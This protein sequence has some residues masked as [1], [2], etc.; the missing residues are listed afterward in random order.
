MNNKNYSNPKIERKI[1]EEGIMKIKSHQE[2]DEEEFHKKQESK[3]RGTFLQEQI[4]ISYEKLSEILY[5]PIR[6]SQK[7]KKS[8]AEWVIDTPAGPAIIYNYKNGLNYKG[9]EGKP[10]YKIKDWHIGT[11]TA[12]AAKIIKEY[13][14][15]KS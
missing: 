3:A 5:E 9:K 14:Q 8:D 2:A 11:R 15:N 7:G 1:N 13:L 4:E 12:E 6:F 10:V